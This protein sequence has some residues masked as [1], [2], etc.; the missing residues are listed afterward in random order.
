[1]TSVSNVLNDLENSKN[2]QKHSLLTH[3]D[4]LVDYDDSDGDSD[5]LEHA[6]NV[7]AVVVD[8]GGVE[9]RKMS[10]LVEEEAEEGEEKDT[11][12]SDKSKRIPVEEEHRRKAYYVPPALRARRA[13]E[14]VNDDESDEQKLQRT[15]WDQ[16][17][18]NIQGTVNRWNMANVRDCVLF[19]FQN[20][21]LI[22]GRGLLA[23]SILTQAAAASTI[24]D[25]LTQVS[26][27]VVA[28]I[29]SK[30]PEVGELILARALSTLREQCYRNRQRNHSSI[31]KGHI[32]FVGHLINQS[33]AHE[34]VALQLLALL[35]QDDNHNSNIEAAIDLVK[36]CANKL[37][38]TS[39]TGLRAVL[40]RLRHILHQG[41]VSDKL[42]YAIEDLLVSSSSSKDTFYIKHPVPE[43]DLV[44]EEDQITHDI[45]M[46]DDSE[47]T[48]GRQDAVD[49]F[50]FD[51]EYK[52]NE[53]TWSK[54]RA[55]IL[56]ED[57]ED[58][59]DD[60]D[61]GDE[62]TVE[63]SVSS[64]HRD[65][66]KEEETAIAAMDPEKAKQTQAFIQDLSEQD[67][68]HL[69]RTIYL[70]IMSSASYEECAHKLASIKIPMGRE[71]ELV[72]MLIECCSQE[73]TF[74][75]YYGLI[76]QRFCL[77][78]ESRWATA[79]I[80]AFN[81][82]YTTIHR[83]E[84]NKLRNVAKLFAHLFHTDAIPWS[85]LEIIHMNEDE[86]TSSS[87]IFVKILIQEMAEA[88]GI[89]ALKQ[90]FFTNED[91]FKG[92]FPK[93]NPRN[94]RYAINFFT[95]I[96]LGA[97]TEGLREHLKNAPMLLLA[98]ARAEAASAAAAA[99]E[100]SSSDSDSLS[101]SSSSTSS[102]SSSYD[103]RRR[104]RSDAKKKIEE[105]RAYRKSSSS[106][107]SYTTS[108]SSSQSYSSSSSSSSSSTVSSSS[109][110]KSPSPIPKRKSHNRSSSDKG[111][112]RSSRRSSSSSYSRSP[113][114]Q[115]K[116]RNNS[117]IENGKGR[118]RR[119]SS[120]S[121]PSSFSENQSRNRSKSQIA[122]R[123][124]RN[125]SCSSSSSQAEGRERQSMKRKISSQ[126]KESSN[127]SAD[128]EAINR[129]G[130]L[131]RQSGP[132]RSKSRSDD[133]SYSSS[134]MSESKS[135]SCSRHK[136]TNGKNN[137]SSKDEELFAKADARSKEIIEQTVRQNEQQFIT[138]KEA[139][140]RMR[141]EGSSSGISRQEE[142]RRRIE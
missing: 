69:R 111:R 27:A 97:L 34:I 95:S 57:D 58:N 96:G 101:T 87:R 1:M 47:T 85:A 6:K 137:S 38:E 78:R 94:T 76:G 30:L 142:K 19:L 53:Q 9:E 26:A 88:L 127:I 117:N 44:E 128:I 7:S 115:P 82:Q 28:V 108:S 5:Q 75:R 68:I 86:T 93:D 37:Q 23:R 133:G 4:D 84:T 129:D 131:K 91:A 21:N 139:E 22:R 116:Q 60:D 32:I 79:F 70:T 12:N 136:D 107:S 36:V 98:Q 74:I 92:M 67:L 80:R 123:K 48:T 126:I 130:K 106:Y 122:N 13:A 50:R 113:S 134:S 54:I 51:E 33:V 71:N 59:E 89:D 140:K 124:K 105:K 15:S 24:D 41:L 77:L 132:S 42:Q 120:D 110:S 100:S 16:L 52:E 72:N 49:T 109:Y 3:E 56:G 45:G 61:K 20:V 31:T 90:R 43:L 10:T 40:E 141:S 64:I 104:R 118:R 73:R 125:D 46:D 63:Q 83:L 55:E 18:A 99:A 114:P 135:S 112:R 14:S 8:R 81:E 29:N 102:S 25:K 119:S 35:L 62:S 11:N 17:K 65:E 138:N 121:S 103:R 2:V 66:E 39:P